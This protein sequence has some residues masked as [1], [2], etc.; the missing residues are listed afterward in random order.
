M[1]EHKNIIDPNIHEPKGASIAVIGTA[2]V[3][4]GAGSGAWE[5]VNPPGLD[6]ANEGEY[7]RANGSGGGTWMLQ[8]HGWGHYKHGGVDQVI[9]STTSKVIIDGL[10]GT[11]ES[12][13]LP[14]EIRGISELWDAVTNKITP[15]SVGDSYSIRIDLPIVAETGSVTNITIGVDIG[16]GAA[17]TDLIVN[18]HVTAGNAT[19]YTIS[20]GIPIFSLATF[21]TNGGQIFATTDVGTAT[22]SGAAIT[23]VRSSAGGG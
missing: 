6:T 4:D 16:G 7:F 1:A 21:I 10:A 11:S 15:I 17:P 5:V 12:S 18:R 8:P 23:I 22:I 3:S 9:N 2:Y 14:R 20:I 13:Y 19:P